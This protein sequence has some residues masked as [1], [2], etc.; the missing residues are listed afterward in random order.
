MHG[1]AAF[2]AHLEPV[3][4]ELNIKTIHKWSDSPSTQYK[5]KTNFLLFSYIE[6]HLDVEIA[7]W[8]FFNLGMESGLQIRLEEQSRE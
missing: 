8:N 2:S 6:K 1:P 4:K 7:T 5:N 3:V